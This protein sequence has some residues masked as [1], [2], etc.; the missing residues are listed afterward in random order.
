MLNKRTG[1]TFDGF[2]SL[3][4]VG[5]KNGIKNNECIFGRTKKP[6]I[7]PKNAILA[8]ESSKILKVQKWCQNGSTAIIELVTSTFRKKRI[9]IAI[10]RQKVSAK[11][12]FTRLFLSTQKTK[13][14]D[15]KMGY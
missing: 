9:L 1:T 8:L 2:T 6:K 13:K 14:V 12:E 5:K 3:F 10:L 7:W 15:K 11:I 4:L